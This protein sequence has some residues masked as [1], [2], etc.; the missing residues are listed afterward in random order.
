MTASYDLWLVAL[1][2][3]VAMIGAHA[4]LS[5]F[6]M[7]DVRPWMTY[8]VRISLGAVAIGA[9]IWVMHFI[10]MLALELPAPIDYAVLPTLISALMAIVFTGLGLYGATSGYFGKF[11]RLFGAGLMGS[12]ISVM[13]YTGMEA[14]R[15]TCLV[16]YSPV[17]VGFSVLAGV[18]ASY[19]ALRMIDAE[20][21]APLSLVGA[22]ALLGLAISS[23]H[24]IGMWSTQI[25]LAPGVMQVDAPVL[26][27]TFLACSAAVLTFFLCDMVLLLALPDQ[28][29]RRRAEDAEPWRLDLATVFEPARPAFA[30]E[31]ETRWFACERASAPNSGAS[32]SAAW[33]AAW[34]ANAYSF[35]LALEPDASAPLPDAEPASSRAAVEVQCGGGVRLAPA[36]RVL[37][38]IAEGRYTRILYEDEDGAL[39]EK[40]C[41]DAISKLE[42]ALTPVG[43]LRT[44]RSYLIN[45]EKVSGYRRTRSGGALVFADARAPEAAVS[46]ARCAEVMAA[47]RDRRGAI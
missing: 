31:G 3:V 18:G 8:K 35:E 30:G 46:R 11:G 15:V 1:S 44:H 21:R 28:R 22:A 27:E 6:A 5:L 2:I 42:A 26:S 23:M 36:E 24:Y 14:L 7:G 29:A 45:I 25:A 13:H 47:V 39:V 4:G 33:P 37:M 19:L 43:F 17:G 41:D 10:G 40:P 32:W 38:A 16:M 20:R 34:P 12:G 9:G